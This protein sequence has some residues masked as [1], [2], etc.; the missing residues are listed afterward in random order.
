MAHQTENKDTE[1]SED[2][3][4]D[5]ENKALM[6]KTEKSEFDTKDL[7]EK[8]IVVKADKNYEGGA[9]V[10]PKAIK[11]KHTLNQDVVQH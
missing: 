8:L 10:E 7:K 9:V 11:T 3:N 1:F 6:S 2:P 5:D 4:E